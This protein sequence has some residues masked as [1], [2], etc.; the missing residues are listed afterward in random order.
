[1][2][3]IVERYGCEEQCAR[4]MAQI[5]AA[6]LRLVSRCLPVSPGEDGVVLADAD[7]ATRLR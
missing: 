2:S 3:E 7:A 1:M 5:Q 6:A 4:A